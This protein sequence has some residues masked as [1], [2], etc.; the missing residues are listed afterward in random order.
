MNYLYLFYSYE[1]VYIEYIILCT[2]L[3][4]SKRDENNTLARVRLV[5]IEKEKTRNM[6]IMV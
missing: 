6:I 2:L 4:I 3:I 1:E 5:V